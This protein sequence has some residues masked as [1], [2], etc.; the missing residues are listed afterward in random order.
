MAQVLLM[1]TGGEGAKIEIGTHT[2]ATS[3]SE[4]DTKLQQVVAML[5]C[6]ID[7]VGPYVYSDLAITT[8]K[9]TV[10]EY[11]AG[12]TNNYTYMFIGL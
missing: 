4:A 10:A 2:F 5:A 1:H 9:V 7:S 11:G 3:T 8:H 12:T 6:C